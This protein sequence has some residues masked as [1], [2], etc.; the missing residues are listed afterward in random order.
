MSRIAGRRFDGQ[1]PGEQGQP[2]PVRP[3]Q[4]GL[5]LRPFTLGDGKLMTLQDLLV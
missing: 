2:C 3:R 5:S 1:R 4:P